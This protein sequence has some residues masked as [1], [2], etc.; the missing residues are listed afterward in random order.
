LNSRM[1]IAIDGPAGAGKSTVCKL[2]AQQLGYTYLDTGAMYR[3]LAW[4][5]LAENMNLED[6]SGMAR[7]IEILPLRFA[8]ENGALSV[9]YGQKRLDQELRQPEI[10]ERASRISQLKS[11]RD[12][13]TRWQ[14]Q[15][16]ERGAIVA[17]GRDMTTVVFPDAPVRIYLTADIKARTERRLLEYC[18]KGIPTDPAVLEAQIRAR[19]EADE[20]RALAPLRAAP[21]VCLVDTSHMS[22]NEV[23]DHLL[24]MIHRKQLEKTHELRI[25]RSLSHCC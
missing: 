19:D 18:D 24:G 10:S 2:L 1:I 15:L 4:I 5:A 6:E 8:I 21:G 9:F 11:V 7:P 16:G 25:E 12:Y 17:E 3:A 20:Q 13:L 22:I 14:R 23:V